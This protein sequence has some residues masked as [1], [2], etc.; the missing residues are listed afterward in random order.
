MLFHKIVL[1]SRSLCDRI[2]KW[3]RGS[4][5][6]IYWNMSSVIDIIIRTELSLILTISSL[7]MAGKA[8][9]MA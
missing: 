3:I 9:L 6:L 2:A 7:P 8:F 5:F 1:P 4:T